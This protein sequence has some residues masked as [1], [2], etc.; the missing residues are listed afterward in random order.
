MLHLLPNSIACK[1][2][3][4]LKIWLY[5]QSPIHANSKTADLLPKSITCR[6]N[7]LHIHTTQSI[8]V[9]VWNILLSLSF[10]C[11]PLLQFIADGAVP[12]PPFH[13]P[14]PLN[15]VG[16]RSCT[17]ASVTFLHQLFLANQPRRDGRL[18]WTQCTV[19][20]LKNN[21]NPRPSRSRVR[22][23]TT[24]QRTTTSTP[25]VVFFHQTL[26]K[27]G[28][29]WLPECSHFCRDFSTR[30]YTPRTPNLQTLSRP[31]HMYTTVTLRP[32]TYP[33]Q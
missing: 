27:F 6:F 33:P 23:S 24:L 5:R 19:A 13:S 11:G 21:S 14:K 8:W 1:F 25:G 4:P 15:I 3:C 17:L 22:H 29:L 16:H 2:Q 9:Y 7:Y 20:A 12:I 26:S 31:L 18:S 30:F 28:L 32:L 10:T